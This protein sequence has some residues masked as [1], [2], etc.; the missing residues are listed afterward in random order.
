MDGTQFDALT[1]RLSVRISRRGV[2]GL[3]AVAALP[4]GRGATRALAQTGSDAADLVL[5]FYENIDA[6]QYKDA[7]ALLGSKWHTQQSQ[8]NFTRGYANTAFVQCKTTDI[9]ASGDS[10][11]VG[12]ELISWHNDGKIVAY[13]GW[14]TVGREGGELRI[15]AGNNTPK[16]APA[17]TPPLCKT[18]DVSFAFGA[19]D[20]GAGNRNSTVVGRNRTQH[21]C[22][23]GGVPRVTLVDRQGHT[24]VS[25]SQPGSAPEGIVL[26]PKDR[27]Q[28]P[29]RFANWCGATS[30]PASVTVEVPGDTT[31]TAKVAYGQNGISYPPC[32]GAGQPAVLEL[33]GWTAVS[34]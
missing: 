11:V 5:Q 7:Y 32:N 9:Q 18:G 21:A 1:R 14:Y 22:V 25:T 34:P 6:F 30:D 31:A 16:A 15:L 8:N 19:W 33:K 4:F 23:L 2:L 27:A 28:A 3:A 20:A 10:T 29:L 13:D 12:V 24:L 26:A 17:G